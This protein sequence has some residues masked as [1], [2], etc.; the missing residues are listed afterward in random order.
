MFSFWRDAATPGKV[1][2]CDYNRDQSG[3]SDCGPEVNAALQQQVVGV[4]HDSVISCAPML[5]IMR[6]PPESA[7]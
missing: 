1:A 7:G 5:K 3:F 2:A 6:A 4:D